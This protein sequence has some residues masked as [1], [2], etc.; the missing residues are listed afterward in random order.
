M[1]KEELLANYFS[2]NLDPEGQRMLEGLLANDPEFKAEFAFENDLKKAIGH[3]EQG[4]L[5]AR[6]RY[7][8]A[9]RLK[10]AAQI[11]DAIEKS[12]ESNFKLMK[13]AAMLLIFLAI[14]W[15]AYQT[16]YGL[17]Y[18]EL[19]QENYQNY[20]NTVYEITRSD[21]DDSVKRQAFVAYEAGNYGEAI[22]K[23]ETLPHLASTDFYLAQSYAQ[24]ENTEKAKNIYRKIIQT[25]DV[26]VAE[27]HWYL[28]LIYLKEEDKKGTKNEL[29]TLVKQYTY[30]KDK[31]KKILDRLD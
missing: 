1:T 21:T 8:E 2:G 18:Q 31:A 24:L 23:F 9:Q 7:H 14:G 27:A 4:D 28:A 3:H 20:P 19:Y 10:D 22:S 15:Y 25:N 30:N 11:N 12:S 26:F 5:K 13:I 29:M 6:L 16:V 17:N